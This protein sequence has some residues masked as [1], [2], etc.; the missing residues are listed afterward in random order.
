MQI[1]RKPTRR[2]YCSMTGFTDILLWKENKHCVWVQL[3]VTL[4]PLLLLCECQKS[5]PTM[6]TDS[7]HLCPVHLLEQREGVGHQDLL[8][9]FPQKN[10][11]NKKTKNWLINFTIVNQLI[12]EMSYYLSD[13]LLR[14]YVTSK[15]S[16]W[17]YTIPRY[18]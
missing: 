13:L 2:Q 3:K 8:T 1:H 5:A 6:D 16:Y 17:G 12:P 7:S 10:L 4:T 14:W 18:P 11:R 9:A 15:W